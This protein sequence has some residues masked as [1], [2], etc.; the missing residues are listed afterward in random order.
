[1]G[2]ANKIIAV[3]T[4]K[5]FI[6][7]IIPSRRQAKRMHLRAQNMASLKMFLLVGVMIFVHSPMVIMGD[8]IDIGVCYGMV[9]ST[10]PSP[11]DVISL[12][13]KYNIGKL[14][15]FDPNP[16]AL[17]ALRGSGIDVTL[18][19]RNEDIPSIAASVKGATSW[20]KTNVQP[21]LTDITFPFISVGNEA[22]PGGFANYIAPAMKNLQAVLNDQ[23]LNDITVTTTVAAMVLGVSYPPS[24]S[25]FSPE[26][27]GALLGVI[28]FL[29]IRRSPLMVNV[30]PYFAYASDPDNVRLDYAL[31]TA[32]DPVV[33]DG[34]LSYYNLFDAVVDSFYWAMEKQ[35]VNNVGVAVSESG[36]PSAGNGN[37][38]TRELASTYNNNFKQ[39]V[40]SNAGTPKRPG[41]YIEGFIFA[42]F[43]EYLKPAGIEQNWGLFYPNMEPVYR[44]F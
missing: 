22:I 17:Q 32:E 19:V 21:Y 40:L 23:N 13:K 6:F 31:F 15:L 44:V 39:H 9:A 27:R 24:A 11:T 2:C 33:F 26:A 28:N 12:Y 41:A 4:N 38:T 16:D 43:N 10:L 1:M 14:R 20:F 37:Y 30:Y 3:V 36:W 42:M 5:N 34:N 35:G 18:G 8:K 25:V 7:Q 29:S